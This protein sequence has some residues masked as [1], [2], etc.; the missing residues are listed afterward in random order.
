MSAAN[1]ILSG[2]SDS[3]SWPRSSFITG[4]D[5]DLF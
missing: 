4:N 1:P 5:P 2:G 3:L